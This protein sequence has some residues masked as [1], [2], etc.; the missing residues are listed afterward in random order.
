MKSLAV[1]L[2]VPVWSGQRQLSSD[3]PQTP[4]Q[5]QTKAQSSDA[6]SLLCSLWDVSALL[7]SAAHVCMFCP[8]QMPPGKLRCHVAPAEPTRGCRVLGPG[9]LATPG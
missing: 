9:T 6:P 1:A 5:L 3:V 7:S 4:E 2:A 8:C